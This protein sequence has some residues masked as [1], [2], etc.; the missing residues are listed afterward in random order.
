MKFNHDLR[1]IQKEA[2]DKL[3]SI[4]EE[5]KNQ[6]EMLKSENDIWKEKLMKESWKKLEE[7]ERKF[8]N[9]MERMETCYSNQLNEAEEE[10]RKREELFLTSMKRKPADYHQTESESNLEIGKLYLEVIIFNY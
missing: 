1:E 2:E 8:R 7:V 5:T 4:L 3:G 6:V 10:A 9:K